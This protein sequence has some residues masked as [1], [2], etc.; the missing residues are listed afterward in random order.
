MLASSV[1]FNRILHIIGAF[2]VQFQSQRCSNKMH[3]KR[4]SADRTG[5]ELRMK[6]NADKPWMRFELDDFNQAIIR[7]NT[8]HDHAV[9]FEQRAIG[10]IEFVAMAMALEDKLLVIGAVCFCAA[11]SAQG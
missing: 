8:A 9:L 1:L 5:F 2:V 11:S 7:G 4:M 10:V 6:L 3:K